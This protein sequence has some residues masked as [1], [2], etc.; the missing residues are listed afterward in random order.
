MKL[1]RRRVEF[2]RI[3]R[4]KGSRLMRLRLVSRSLRVGLMMTGP[5]AAVR[6]A[7][8]QAASTADAADDGGSASGQLR[9]AGRTDG[10]AGLKAVGLTG[11]SARRR[12][13][14]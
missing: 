3:V 2:L 8:G 6:S 13:N 5:R 11:G 12:W 14:D 4:L 10:G 1:P 7:G 9:A